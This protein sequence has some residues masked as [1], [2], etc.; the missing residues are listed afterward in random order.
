[1]LKDQ[2]IMKKAKK[3]KMIIMDV[4]GVLTDGRI[5]LGNKGEEL[6]N[7]YVQDGQGIALAL[8][9]GLIIALVSG[10]R[11]KVVERRAEELKIKEVY[12]NIS[13]KIEVYSRLLKKYNLKDEEVAYIGDDLGDILPLKKVGLSLAP[14]NGVEEVRGIVH[15]VTRASGGRG[16]VRE[17]IDIILKAKKTVKVTFKGYG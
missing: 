13:K 1:M 8:Q 17:A 12:Q 14:A 16:A 15:Y 3:I 5:I 11:S 6:K 9:K 10:R 4:D 2:K 7:F